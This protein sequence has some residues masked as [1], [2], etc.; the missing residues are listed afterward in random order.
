MSI[1]R[2]IR[3]RL[4]SQLRGSPPPKKVVGTLYPNG[5]FSYAFVPDTAEVSWESEPDE[6]PLARLDDQPIAPH[7]IDSSRPNN[8]HRGFYQELKPK[9]RKRYG[10]NG[11]SGTA[12]RKVRSSAFLL[13]DRYTKEKLSFLTLTVPPLSD[14]EAEKTLAGRWGEAVQRFVDRLKKLMRKR[15]LP[16]AFVGVTELQT[17]RYERTG[18]FCLHLHILFV[19]RRFLGEPWRIKCSDVREIWGGII[20]D[21]IGQ[22]IYR[23]ALE[24]LQGVRRSGEGYLGKYMSKNHNEV[25]KVIEDGNE[26]MLPKQWWFSTY[27]MKKWLKSEVFKGEQIGQLLSA[28]VWEI[29]NESADHPVIYYRKIVIKFESMDYVAGGVGRLDRKFFE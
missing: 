26:W 29:E 3:E 20:E 12:R 19:G 13:Q 10:I 25:R 22:C 27:Q 4:G 24:N 28:M 16:L 1:A 7:P 15:D 5:E 11:M 21:I 23:G 14:R 8:S 9:Q 18:E 2:E 6:Y 17:K